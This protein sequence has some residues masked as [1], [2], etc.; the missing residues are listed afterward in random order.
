MYNYDLYLPKNMTITFLYYIK[1][2]LLFKRVVSDMGLN[3][4]RGLP[5][6]HLAAKG[7]PGFDVAFN[8]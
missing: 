4:R 7:Y 5:N 6:D 1:G 8:T 3:C 2:G